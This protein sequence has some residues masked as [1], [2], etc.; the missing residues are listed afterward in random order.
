MDGR[1]DMDRE[2][3]GRRAAQAWLRQNGG[4]RSTKLVY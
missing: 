2:F 3:R 1:D 4:I